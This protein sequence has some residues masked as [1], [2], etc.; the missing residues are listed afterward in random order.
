M[1]TRWLLVNFALLGM[2]SR[3]SLLPFS[4]FFLEPGNI[5]RFSSNL[6]DLSLTSY[7]QSVFIAALFSIA[8]LQEN[9][10]LAGLAITVRTIDLFGLLFLIST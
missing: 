4:I 7:F 1:T 10:G 2:Y 3:P 8:T 9:A 6:C 5:V